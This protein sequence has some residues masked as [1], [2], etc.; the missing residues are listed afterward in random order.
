MDASYEIQQLVANANGT[1][2][3]RPLSGYVMSQAEL[4]CADIQAREFLIAK[5]LPMDSYGMVYAARG[6]GKSWFCMALAVAI[7]EGKKR[8]LPWDLNGQHNVLY[9]DGEMT[10]ADLKERFSELCRAPLH[11]LFIMPSEKLFRDGVPICLDERE[12]Q[13]Q[14][15]E[16]LEEFST[17]G[18]RPQ[19][20]IFD[21]LSTLRRGV[22]ENDNDETRFLN[23]WFIRLR[24]FGYTVIIVHHAGKSGQQRGA[25]ILEVPMD[26]VIKLS[27]SDKT[28]T[29]RNDGAVFDLELDKVRCRA[30][31]TDTLSLSLRP[32]NDGITKLCFEANNDAIEPRYKLLKDLGLN[33]RRTYRDISTDLGFSTG[34]IT[35][36]MKILISEAYLEGLT[37]NAKITSNGRQLL[38]DLWPD[39]FN[40]PQELNLVQDENLPF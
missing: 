20:L 24:S 9:I 35:N 18:N 8:F 22:S 33:G 5:W 37:N 23:D 10:T 11:N 21:N 27:R 12:E 7:A 13:K 34:A 39:E 36:Y 15:E 31:S 2:E 29:V 3:K 26:Y 6:V 14:F 30:P 19:V 1:R 16:M 4:A 32:D 40:E 28:K 25:S 38:Y 17:A